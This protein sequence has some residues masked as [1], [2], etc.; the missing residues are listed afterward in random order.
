MELPSFEIA[1]VDI[2]SGRVNYAI[3]TR[4]VRY[5]TI[6]EVGYYT[7]K[8]EPSSCSFTRTEKLEVLRVEMEAKAEPDIAAFYGK[9]VRITNGDDHGRRGEVFMIEDENPPLLRVMLEARDRPFMPPM[10]WSGW[11]S[12]VEIIEEKT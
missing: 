6:S 11:A 8:G 9:R 4:F 10:E 2:E 3:Q 12:E 1:F 5:I 7:L